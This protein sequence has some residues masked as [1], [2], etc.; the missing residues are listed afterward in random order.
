MQCFNINRK[1]R[2]SDTASWHAEL[3]S[4]SHLTPKWKEK[5]NNW[6]SSLKSGLYTVIS[7]YDNSEKC[8]QQKWSKNSPTI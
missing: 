1:L 3:Y 7:M 6:S 2:D 4:A 8:V 5:F